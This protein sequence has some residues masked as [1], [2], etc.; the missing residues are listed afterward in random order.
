MSVTKRKRVK[1]IFGKFKQT[2]ISIC[3]D[4]RTYLNVF[5]RDSFIIDEINAYVNGD[6]FKRIFINVSGLKREVYRILTTRTLV[7]TRWQIFYF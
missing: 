3:D 5:S 6:Y 4:D 7:E 2:L 1:V